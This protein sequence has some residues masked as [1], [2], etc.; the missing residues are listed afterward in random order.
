M[1][2]VKQYILILITTCV[3][4][5]FAEGNI[6]FQHFDNILKAHQNHLKS[7]NLGADNT[8]IN[9][10]NNNNPL[11]LKG[12]TNISLISTFCKEDGIRILEGNSVTVNLNIS[13][14][15]CT[16]YSKINLEID[17]FYSVQ[18]GQIEMIHIE[19]D[20][21]IASVNITG[22]FIGITQLSLNLIDNQNMTIKAEK[23]KIFVFREE[24]ILDA[25]F[26]WLLRTFVILA[27]VTFG[28]GIDFDNVR[29]TFQKPVAVF[30]GFVSQIV[31]VPSV[32]TFRL[33]HVFYFYFLYIFTPW[34]Y[35]Y[36][37][38]ALQSIQKIFTKKCMLFLSKF[39]Y[40]IQKI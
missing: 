21:Y 35:A 40:E 23:C 15:F 13:C 38:N 19:N 20:F 29:N 37:K 28:C 8:L 16:K 11:V 26:D 31:L 3:F 33:F 36:L 39:T 9:I 25:V 10:S 2:V 4:L 32:S 18:I 22:L 5:Q 12:N 27:N 24:S 30:L 14:P 7:P 34:F 1:E 17:H 6:E